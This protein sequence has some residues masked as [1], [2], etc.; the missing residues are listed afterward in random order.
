MCIRDRPKGGPFV[1]LNIK[2]LGMNPEKFSNYLLEDFGIPTVPGNVFQ[3][4]DHV[5]IA[6]GA[7]D[8]ML[9]KVLGKLETAI[10]RVQKTT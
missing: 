6:F 10:I 4:N 9:K 1:F 7:T 3:S 2:Q 8:Q 5:R